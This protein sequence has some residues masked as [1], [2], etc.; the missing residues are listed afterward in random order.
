[1]DKDKIAKSLLLQT[2]DV[3]EF[4][5]QAP[6]LEWSNG[7]YNMLDESQ[8][9]CKNRAAFSD[10]SLAFGLPEERTCKKWRLEDEIQ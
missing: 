2:C 10:P 8:K 5:F 9:Y 4:C 7:K 1:M 3:C 6:R